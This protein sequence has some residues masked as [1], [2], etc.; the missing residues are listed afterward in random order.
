MEVINGGKMK[1]EKV[2]CR[3]FHL[4]G[5]GKPDMGEF[6]DRIKYQKIVYLLQAYGLSVGY[7]FGWYL[8]SPYSSE[9]AHTLYSIYTS[10][11]T[12]ENV[13]KLK[14]REHDKVI[15]KIMEFKEILG[16][17]IDD[18]LYI[19]I[20]SSILFIDY[21]TYGGNGSFEALKSMLLEIKN[22][23]E[24]YARFNDVVERAYKDLD[25]YKEFENEIH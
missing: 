19:D 2:L 7:G 18:D 9:L 16:D 8:K 21:A 25:H 24:D 14:F 17:K 5:L 23:L 10:N 13:E 20:L 15:K 22:H 6:K 4:L 3:V 11:R 1:T 12:Y